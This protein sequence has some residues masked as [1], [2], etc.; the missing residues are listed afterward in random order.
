MVDANQQWDVNV[1]IERARELAAFRPWWVEEPTSPDDILGH[2]T[3][4]QA[5][6]PPGM[7]IATGE[8]C[9]NRVIFKQLMQAHAIDFCQIDSCRLGGVNEN[10]AVILMAAKFG[11]PVCPHAGGVG[12]CE[13]VQHLSMFDYI[14]V[15]GTMQD[16]VTEY[17]DHLHEH[18]EDPVSIRRDAISRRHAPATA[19][20]FGPSR[21]SR[22]GFRTAPSGLPPR[23]LERMAIH[24]RRSTR[25]IIS[26][27]SYPRVASLKTAAAF[28]AHLERGRIPLQF[29]DELADPA[30]SPLAQPIDV[31][32]IRVGNRFCILP[33]E[34]WDGTAGG[35]PTD[36]TAGAGA[37]SE[38]AE[39]S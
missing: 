7:G 11:M 20:R 16:R 12:L 5:L 19:S 36:L 39:R 25:P 10:L 6:R 30:L 1:A 29:D 8:H 14:A 34:G 22:T 15:S 26:S 4:A 18:F 32:G 38:S 31:D 3:I 33:M 21:G 24:A 17:V 13:Y 2:A 28:R 9:A 23:E 35:E 37:T 27:D